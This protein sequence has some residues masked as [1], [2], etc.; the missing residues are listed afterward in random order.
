MKHLH[1]PTK[2]LH[3]VRI[4]KGVYSCGSSVEYLRRELV[5]QYCPCAGEKHPL[6]RIVE[7]AAERE[8]EVE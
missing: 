7:F 6:T 4:Y 8:I 3:T 1:R 5:E 2:K